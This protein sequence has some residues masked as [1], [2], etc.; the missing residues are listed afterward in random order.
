[1]ETEWYQTRWIAF[2]VI[3]VGWPLLT[4]GIFK[5]LKRWRG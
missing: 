5:L 4:A 1:M 3:A 2:L